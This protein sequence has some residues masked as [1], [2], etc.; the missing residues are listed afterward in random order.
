MPTKVHLVKAMVSP[1]VMYGY[2]SWTIEEAERQ[3]INAF[4]P[5]KNWC[6]LTVVLEKSLE[7]PLDCKEI[8]PVNPKRN[9][10]W[11]FIGRT[12]AEAETPVL[13]PPDAKSWVIG[14]DPDA[15]KDR[16]QERG[17]KEDEMLGWYHQLK[18]ISL[19]KLWE[20]VIDRETWRSAVHEVTRSRTQ[21]SDWTDWWREI[22]FVFQSIH[23]NYFFLWF[24]KLLPQLKINLSLCDIW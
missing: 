21:L 22:V 1:I 2:Q 19:S 9:Q 10:F 17:V 18:D 23:I 24:Q 4:E 5:P 14:K 13:W 7:S 15:G 6:F 3:R 20:L 16:R 11:I 8:K 12:N